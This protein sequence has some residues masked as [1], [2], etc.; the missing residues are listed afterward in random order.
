M[1]SAGWAAVFCAGSVWTD[2]VSVFCWT[3]AAGCVVP[4]AGTDVCAER[5]R[6]MRA[7][8]MDA[9]KIVPDIFFI[10]SFL[11]CLMLFISGSVLNI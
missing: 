3:G 5:G 2:G 8:A 11:S 7:S 1:L 10:S 6:V 9:I 4:A